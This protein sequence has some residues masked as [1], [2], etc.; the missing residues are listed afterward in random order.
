MTAQTSPS[1]KG[2]V[3]AVLGGPV[4]P[5]VQN[6]GGGQWRGSPALP[7]SHQVPRSPSGRP[8]WPGLP[9]SNS[10]RERIPGG[11]EAGGGLEMRR[12]SARSP[13][14]LDSEAHPGL[15]RGPSVRGCR[16]GRCQGAGLRRALPRPS[17]P[18]RATGSGTWARC[19]E[20]GGSWAGRAEP[21]PWAPPP[22]GVFR[23]ASRGFPAA[24]VGGDL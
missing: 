15:A 11:S 17:P 19:G 2:A 23:R 8:L 7:P 21:G 16:R 1:T 22:H 4:R 24:G 18:T 14:F 6:C 9:A 13:D 10:R 3:E 20:G 12:A 5:P